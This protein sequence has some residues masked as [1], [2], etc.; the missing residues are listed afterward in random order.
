MAYRWHIL[1]GEY[2]PQPGGVSDYT[3]LIARGLALA[4][5]DVQVW[6][7]AEVRPTPAEPGV[8]VR[9]LPDHFGPRGLAQ[10]DAAL[11][12][13][14]ASSRILVQ[15]VPHMYG[16]KAMNLAF[17][18]WLRL[19]VRRPWVMFHEVAFPIQRGQK[20]K[21]NFLGGVTRVMAALVAAA[22]ERIFVSVP[23]WQSVLRSCCGV[24][25]PA[26]WLPVPSNMPTQAD[27]DAVRRLRADLVPSADGVLVGHFG[28]L[29]EELAVLL[30]EVLPP[31]LRRDDARRA[32]L[33]GKDSPWFAQQWR[34]QAPDLAP[35]LEA[36]AGLSAAAVA[37]HLAACDL[38]IQPYLDGVSSRRGSTMAGLALGRPVLTTVGA[39]TESLWQE[40]SLVEMV[41]LDDRP[42]VLQR[43]E[44]LLRSLAAR[45]QL[46]RRGQLGYEKNFCCQRTIATLRE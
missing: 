24:R 28:S 35:R 30:L 6:A 18:S 36:R 27:A 25:R 42:G 40:E 19:R 34:Q 21:H 43:A 23:R 39:A 8:Q 31:L 10:L 5:D 16:C 14:P 38:L 3:R 44:D 37:E 45:Q 20:L 17:C 46:G 4:G 15:Y 2:P 13:E 26:Q 32:L 22:A 12:R 7:P 41:P 1:T 11:Q 33:I 9:R 29:R